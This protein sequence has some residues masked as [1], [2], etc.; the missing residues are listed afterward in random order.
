[1][2]DDKLE[3]LGGCILLRVQYF[4]QSAGVN[5]PARHLPNA[6]A[7]DDVVVEYLV[8]VP[9]FELPYDEFPQGLAD[10]PLVEPPDGGVDFLSCLL[11]EEVLS[12]QLED[13]SPPESEVLLQKP[14]EH[15]E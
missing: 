13:S 15:F 6:H 3:L 8:V 12:A 14:I 11:A 5:L 7:V 2:L 10:I 9:Y 4:H 1:M